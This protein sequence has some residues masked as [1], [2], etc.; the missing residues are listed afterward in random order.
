MSDVESVS[1]DRWR[2]EQFVQM[3]FSG[4][5]AVLLNEWGADLH[6]ARKL[7]NDGCPPHL[8]MR[9]LRPLDDHPAYNADVVDRIR[10]HTTV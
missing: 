4:S 10:E 3:G 6:Y 5:A 1:V 9:I 2:H 7:V 8:A